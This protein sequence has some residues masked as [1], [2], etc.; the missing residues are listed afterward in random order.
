MSGHHRPPAKRHAMAFRWLVDD[1][2]LLVLF[3]IGEHYFSAIQKIKKQN[4][5]PLAK[6]SG[7]AHDT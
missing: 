2:P 7:S 4:G 1:G 6:P 5:H 3:G